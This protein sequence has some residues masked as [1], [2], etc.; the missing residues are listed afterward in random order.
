MVASV[1]MCGM[2]IVLIAARG[3]MNVLNLVEEHA[4]V[5]E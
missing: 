4:E 3:E 2:I 1:K 5:E